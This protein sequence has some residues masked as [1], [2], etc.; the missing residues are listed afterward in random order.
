MTIRHLQMDMLSTWKITIWT[1]PIYVTL[2]NRV[3]YNGKFKCPLQSSS[4]SLIFHW[5]DERVLRSLKYKLNK[6][7]EFPCV[8]SGVEKWWAHSSGQEPSL[9]YCS[10]LAAFFPLQLSALAAGFYPN[11]PLILFFSRNFKKEMVFP[12]K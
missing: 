9:N 7:H 4:D 1:H 12:F 5:T 3:N 10:R 2:E 11:P 6:F 8:T